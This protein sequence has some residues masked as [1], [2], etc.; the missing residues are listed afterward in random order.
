MND[1]FVVHVRVPE[2][3]TV[4]WA[5]LINLDGHSASIPFTRVTPEGESMRPGLR[6][7]GETSLGPLHFSDRMVVQR[8]DAPTAAHPGHLV[9]EKFGPVA[10]RVEATV[11]QVA[12]GTL[13][14]WQQSL[15]PAW[16]PTFLRPAGTVVA[17]IA[18]GT[19]LRQLLS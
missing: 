9:V 13:V 18:Y 1:T 14:T 16:L 6:F 15:R 4:V 11:E 17:R 12:T 3:A 19:G 5:R 2:P 7:V 10:G 8:A